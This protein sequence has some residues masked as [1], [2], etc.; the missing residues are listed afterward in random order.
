MRR[1]PRIRIRNS[2]RRNATRKSVEKSEIL[3]H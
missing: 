2:S 3:K 1:N